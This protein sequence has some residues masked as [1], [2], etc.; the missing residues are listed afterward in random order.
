MTLFTWFAERIEDQ[1]FAAQALVVLYRGSHS[2]LGEISPGSEKEDPIVSR[3]I[4]KK[5]LSGV[6]T[7]ASSTTT[8]FGDVASEIMGK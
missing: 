8:I 4:L 2:R 6:R 3:R 1:K 5:A 7:V